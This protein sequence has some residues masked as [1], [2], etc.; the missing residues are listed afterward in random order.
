MSDVRCHT[1][2]NGC[3]V[4]IR[5][6]PDKQILSMM[7]TARWGGRDDGPERAGI[8]NLM[9]ELLVKGTRSRTALEIAESL[10]SVGGAIDPFCSFDSMGIETQTVQDDWRMALEVM[11][12]C[13][14]DSTFSGE[15]FEKEKTLI[16]AEILRDEDE[17]FTYTYKHL[18]GLMYR[19][20]P[21][22]VI[23]EGTVETV[24]RLEREA[25]VALHSRALRPE[26]MLLVAVGNVPTDEFLARVESLWPAASVSPRSRPV[27]QAPPGAG[28][29][30]T[31]RL[32]K[33]VEQGFVVIGYLAP[34]P[35]DPDLPALR[36]ACGVLGEGM[37]AR[38]FSRL[39]DRDHLAYA[40]GSSLVSRDLASQLVLYIGTGPQ[41]VEPGLEG[42]LREAQGLVSEPP[43]IEEFERAR[44][45][46]LGK[47][48]I[49]RQTNAALAHAM[50][51]GEILG[52]G[53]EWGERF[54]ERIRSVTLPQVVEAAE[55]YLIRPAVA[56]LQPPNA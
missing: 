8:A 56:I 11:T 9:A 4:L 19:D 17:K 33:E 42:L 29:G 50:T 37:S 53:W 43:S 38:L 3:T 12:D 13:L 22:A 44:R 31:L 52:L 36:L 26:E 45:Y 7:A 39:R 55:R 20:H 18:Q 1:L 48:L 27:A 28:A 34:R 5:P 46:I 54:P 30:E 6:T 24:G 51:S 15:E 23:P 2:P 41:T 14:F 49:S 40:V 35:G 10:E 16:Q 32:T 21:Y 25:V 47:Y